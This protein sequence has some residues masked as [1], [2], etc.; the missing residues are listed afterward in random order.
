MHKSNLT[1]A[2]THTHTHI[3]RLTVLHD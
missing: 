1:Q 2:F 3:F